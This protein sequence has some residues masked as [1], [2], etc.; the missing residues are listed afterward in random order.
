MGRLLSLLL[1]GALV[2]CH[3]GHSGGRSAVPGVGSAGG[4]VGGISWVCPALGILT[5][6]SIATGNWIGAAGFALT[7]ARSGCIA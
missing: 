6:V 5:G 2:L 4:V 7:A 3:A 1:V